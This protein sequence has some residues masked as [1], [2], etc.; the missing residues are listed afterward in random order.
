MV[1]LYKPSAMKVEQYFSYFSQQKKYIYIYSKTH[2]Y[3]ITKD[4]NNLKK[5]TL[6]RLVL[7]A[8]PIH[9]LLKNTKSTLCISKLL[10]LILTNS[11]HT[12]RKW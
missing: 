6:P 5:K 4:H 7:Q 9:Q 10:I 1:L 8:K 3:L 2:L 11:D 12:I